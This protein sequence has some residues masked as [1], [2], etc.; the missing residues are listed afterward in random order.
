M[1]PIRSF[2][3]RRL[4]MLTEPLISLAAA[5]VVIIGVLC[6]FAFFM[7]KIDANDA[8]ISVM[9]TVALG[10]GAYTGGY[11]S[12]RRRKRNG[13][14]MGVLCGVFIFLVILILSA[15]FSKAVQSF[16]PSAKLIVTLVC[17]A[18]GGVVGVNSR[19]S[20]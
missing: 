2:R 1:R 14:L 16:S 20:L 19:K 11:V 7:T 4:T 15:F 5:F 18:V 12:A 6:I 17:A 8:A 10:A 9:T 3:C 13:L